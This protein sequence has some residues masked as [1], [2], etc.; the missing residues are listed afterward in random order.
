MSSIKLCVSA[1]LKYNILNADIGIMIHSIEK[2]GP[3]RVMESYVAELR[4]WALDYS[5]RG[6]EVP[7]NIINELFLAERL[8][9]IFLENPEWLQLPN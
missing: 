3:L 6:E 7:E 2:N 9:K 8:A 1:L 5:L 4:F